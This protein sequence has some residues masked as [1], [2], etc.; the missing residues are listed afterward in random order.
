VHWCLLQ[1]GRSSLIVLVLAGFFIV[2]CGLT[3]Y[4]TVGS[5]MQVVRHPQGAGAVGKVCAAT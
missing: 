5:V 2:A 3:Y 1:V 4:I